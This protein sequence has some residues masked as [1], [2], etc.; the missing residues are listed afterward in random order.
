MKE[1][2]IMS[3]GKY[4]WWEQKKDFVKALFNILHE[5]NGFKALKKLMKCL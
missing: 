4:K 5:G 3:E 2:K 1:K